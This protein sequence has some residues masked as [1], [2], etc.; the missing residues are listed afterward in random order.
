MNRGGRREAI[1]DDRD[2]ELFVATLTE[3]PRFA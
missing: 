2:W 1:H 3:A